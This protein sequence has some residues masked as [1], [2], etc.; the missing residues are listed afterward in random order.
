VTHSTF[1]DPVQLRTTAVSV[2]NGNEEFQRYDPGRLDCDESAR[3]LLNDL[4]DRFRRVEIKELKD[5]HQWCVRVTVRE[6]NREQRVAAIGRTLYRAA[7]RMI[8][9][10]NMASELLT[11]GKEPIE[12]LEPEHQDLS[13]SIVHD[14]RNKLTGVR[15]EHARLNILSE[16]A[17]M[18]RQDYDAAFRNQG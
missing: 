16:V 3:R 5:S 4:D 17:E 8:S 6:G 7:R 9:V 10:A 1:T 13:D 14:I 2:H 15:D 12:R 11:S 18:I